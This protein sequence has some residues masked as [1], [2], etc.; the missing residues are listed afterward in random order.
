MGQ[1]G[2]SVAI[3]SFDSEG[4]F[5]ETLHKHVYAS[6]PIKS[7]ESLRGRS[8]QVV[9]I[10][11]ALLSPG[12]NVFIYGD[13]GVGKTSLA[14]TAAFQYNESGSEPILLS[15]DRHSTFGGLIRDL[16][17]RGLGQD[18]TLSKVKRTSEAGANAIGLSIKMANEIETGR[19]SEP[20][21]VNEAVSLIEYLFSKNANPRVA[22]VD[23]FERLEDEGERSLFADFI[24][25]LGDRTVYLKFIFCGVGESL[26]KL[27]LD[28]HSC[29]RYLE[30]VQLE[31]LPWNARFEIVRS[32]G[33]AFSVDV[34]PETEF[35]IAAISDGFP[36]YIHLVTE[37]LFWQVFDD[38]DDVVKIKPA[39]YNEAVKNAVTGIEPEL[40]AT[41]DLATRKY[42]NDYD[43]V[44]WAAADHSDLERRS[45]E[46][47]TSYQRI[48][49]RRQDEMLDRTKFNQRINALKT[50]SHGN[51]LQGTRQG[52]YRFR[53]NVV[54]GYVRLRA[55]Q[56]GV[57]LDADHAYDANYLTSLK[58]L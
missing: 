41:Y 51:I 3:S 1:E 47:F 19:L 8:K 4:A 6:S 28:H 15:L 58:S 39:H 53:E 32:A 25:Q 14:Q 10:E 46:I 50:S 16:A 36:Y 33:N 7:I 31:R 35:R 38:P 11:R 13:R 56:A 9:E 24:K 5:I 55:E 29:F 48:M 57:R 18:P 42:N 43:E 52:W 22:V 37:K 20:E 21:S 23:E 2:K 54:R 12:R 27:L 17:N 26:N 40:K 34:D 30:S 44:L 45:V 49:K